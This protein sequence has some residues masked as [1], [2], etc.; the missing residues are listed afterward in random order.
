[1]SAWCSPLCKGLCSGYFPIKKCLVLLTT[2]PMLIPPMNFSGSPTKQFGC[3]D[4]YNPLG[5]IKISSELSIFGGKATISFQESE[6]FRPTSPTT[7]FTEKIIGFDKLVIS[8]V[9]LGNSS[10]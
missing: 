9:I 3:L 6:G 1:M 4:V 8:A 5:S 2:F 10:K 7:I